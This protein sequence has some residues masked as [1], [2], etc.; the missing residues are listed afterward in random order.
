[1]QD[2][3][4]QWNVGGEPQRIKN[5][6]LASKHGPAVTHV[7]NFTV[8]CVTDAQARALL[9]LGLPALDTQA[10]A[11]CASAPDSLEAFTGATARA[12]CVKMACSFHCCHTTFWRK[13]RC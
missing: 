2:A 11:S 8:R 3:E 10:F 4:A 6:T 12:T 1:M 7:A 5:A 9:R 13:Q